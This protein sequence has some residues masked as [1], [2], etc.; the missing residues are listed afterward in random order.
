MASFTF[1]DFKS[2][3]TLVYLPSEKKDEIYILLRKL[4]KNGIF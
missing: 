1:N 4:T 3:I 2:Q